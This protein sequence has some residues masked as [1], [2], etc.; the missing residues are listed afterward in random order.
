MRNIIFACAITATLI[1]GCHSSSKQTGDSTISDSAI[2]DS[3]ATNLVDTRFEV[4]S[5]VFNK[6]ASTSIK[7]HIYVDWPCGNDSLAQSV[8]SAI[9]GLLADCY[10]PQTNGDDDCKK[11]YP[12]YKGSFLKGKQMIDYYGNGS[13]KYMKSSQDEQCAFMGNDSS[14]VPPYCNEIEIRKGEETNKYLTY[15]FT[16]YCEL[17]GAH[18]SFSSYSI[19][20]DKRTRK[21][22]KS[23]IN[24]AKSKSMQAILRK[25]VMQYLKDCGED[26][27]DATL[28]SCLMLSDG[29]TIPLPEHSP[30]I[31]ND[32][33][34]FVYQQYEIAPYAV[35]LISFKLP[36]KAIEP[37][38]SK[39]MKAMLND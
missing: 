17:G 37:Y 9:A 12:I 2:N 16:K 29:N 15:D 21:L 28:N 7:S 10:L 36:V 11:A 26:V 34:N 20:F 24:P 23:A 8:K 13:A 5:I 14:D 22:I 33:V 30:W 1:S 32:S 3:T 4:D 18:G 31:A 35:G 19:N 38:L 39:E 25:G 27:T 6:Q